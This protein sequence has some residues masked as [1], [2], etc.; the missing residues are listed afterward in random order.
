[1]LTKTKTDLE[2]L[3][4]LKLPPLPGSV[5][6]ISALL[7]DINVSQKAIAEAVGNDPMLASRV[8]R[9]AN[10]PIYA[11]EQNITSLTGAVNAV[12]NKA[13]YEMVM[14]GVI[15]ESFTRE[16]RNSAA[17]RD[18]WL[19][20]LAVA[21]AAREM[22]LILKM[23]GTEEAFSCGLLH[24]IG[25]LLIFRADAG[26][27][28]ALYNKTV[29]GDDL[30]AERLL[31]GF[32]HAEL[33]AAAAQRWHLPEPVCNMILFHHEP[34][35]SSQGIL[36][37]HIINL[38]DN[39]VYLKNQKMPFDAVFLSSESIRALGFSARQLDAIWDKVVVN[40]REVVKTFFK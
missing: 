36:M 40:L 28:N 8:L 30:P 32:D 14:I 37:T 21:F 19:H 22:S 3:V 15:G 24:D 4:K 26:I 31:L 18:I 2:T 20:S 16:I 29:H 17:G 7:Q 33:G 27:F 9:L 11:F 38:A 34:T 13:I 39:L 35:N 25:K 1:M 12:G 5:L 6:K 23:H 10:S